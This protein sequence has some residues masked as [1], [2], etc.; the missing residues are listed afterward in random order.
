MQIIRSI[1]KMQTIS[2]QLAAQGK[3]IGLVPTMGYLHDGHLSLIKR[4][5]RRAEIV[6]TSIFV[7]PFQFA[8]HE[9]LDK[10]PRDEKGDIKKIALAGGDIVFIPT[11]EDMYTEKFHS[12]LEVLE[13]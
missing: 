4:A 1:K 7:N 5:K 2:R 9:D 12:F 10:Y 13:N 6:V 3:K 11:P 8:P